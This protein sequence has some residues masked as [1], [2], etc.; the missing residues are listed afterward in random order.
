MN[1]AGNNSGVSFLSSATIMFIARPT[2][3]S[4]SPFG[5]PTRGGTVV[6]FRGHA[7]PNSLSSR[8]F[9]G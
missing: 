4:I 9:F 5:G 6:T 7:L 2:I 8:C 1:L 3:T